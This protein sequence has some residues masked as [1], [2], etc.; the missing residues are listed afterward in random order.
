[1]KISYLTS[2][3]FDDLYF[4]N[5]E[6]FPE[7]SDIEERFKFQILLNPLLL[8]K[9]QPQFL[10]AQSDHGEIVGQYGVN[11][12]NYYFAGKC[13]PGLSGYDFI[14]S[15]K[16]RGKGVGSSLLKTVSQQH[17]PLFAIGVSEQAKRVYHDFHFLG[18]MKTFI[19][20]RTALSPL[21]MIVAVLSKD[22]FTLPEF[23]RAREN[24]FPES[25]TV[26]GKTFTR[27]KKVDSTN[28]AWKEDVL[29]FSRSPDFLQWRF[30]TIPGYHLYLADKEKDST[31]KKNPVYFVIKELKWIGLRLL[32]IVDHRIN[33]DDDF[34]VVV[35][36]VKRLASQLK[37]DG[38][39][40]VSSHQFFDHE[41]QKKLFFT[42]GKPFLVLSNQKF[43]FTQK[44]IERR[45]VLHL[46][47][48]DGD[49]EFAYRSLTTPV[50][51]KPGL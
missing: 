41:L 39:L 35:A 44:K 51:K 40:T 8:N 38:I 29:E 37:M 19:W 4:F 12:L 47:P 30:F 21:R 45:Q 2:R 5:K 16:C 18:S 36:A 17:T 33:E 11:S 27:Q 24:T 42:L 7:R 34:S 13:F 14:V 49:I 20:L 32:M 25:C 48:V 31:E 28:Q 6:V 50:H 9:S 10:V 26:R 15:E 1:M 46:T 23:S 22:R 3:D 43:E